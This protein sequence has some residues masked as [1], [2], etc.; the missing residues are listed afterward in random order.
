M[1]SPASISGP[2]IQ[3]DNSAPQKSRSTLKRLVR[4]QTFVLGLVMFSVILIASIMVPSFSPHDPFSQN[5]RARLTPPVW[6]PSGSWANILGADALGR[7]YLVRL[8]FGARTSFQV[9]GLAV[10]LSSCF[11]ITLG[12]IAGF[13][14][15][16]LDSILMRLADI[17][18][19]F[20]FIILCIALLSAIQPTPLLVAVVL[21]IA[22][23][24]L[25]ARMARGMTLSEKGKEYILAATAIGSRK[26][27]IVFRHILPN[28]LPMMVVIA[29]LEFG[30][31]VQIEALLSF[32][33]LGIQPPTPSWGNMLGDG[34]NYLATHP[35]VIILP[36]V[37]LFYSVLS[38]NLIADG[39]RNVLDPG[40][41]G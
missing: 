27:R 25:Y 33:G 30:T 17:Q 12:L 10:L 34:R 32:L 23:W 4:E 13:S 3:F 2:T 14:G 6:E 35:W 41:R 39:L 37:F 21:A 22:D 24:V 28:I 8:L 29:A 16:K 18:L 40:S 7:D 11:G 19:S 36:G 9:S 31:L 38:I 26:S 20:P 15:G 5:L 1:D